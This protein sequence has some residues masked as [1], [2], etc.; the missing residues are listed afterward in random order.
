MYLIFFVKLQ[1]IFSVIR[2]LSVLASI[3]IYIYMLCALDRWYHS[4]MLNDRSTSMIFVALFIFTCFCFFLI[5]YSEKKY[6]VLYIF[7]NPLRYMPSNPYFMPLG[8]K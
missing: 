6:L 3:Y 8:Q 1:N 2:C 5:H 7:K 4:Y